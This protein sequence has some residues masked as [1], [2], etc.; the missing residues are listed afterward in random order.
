MFKIGDITFK[1]NIFLAPMAGVTDY[2]FREICR[3]FG[4]GATYTEMISAKG[5][6]YCNKNTNLLMDLGNGKYE[7]GVQLFGSD[8]DI[9]RYAA[10]C[11]VSAG[12]VLIDINM[13][14]PAPKIVKNGEGCALMAKPALVE[15][16]ISSVTEAVNIPVTV[17]IRKG[18]GNNVNAAEIAQIAQG[19]GAAAITVHG[20]TQSEYY[21]GKADL[22]IIARVKQSVT[23]P[24]IGNGDVISL[25]SAKEMTEKTG[26][27]AVMIGRAAMGNPWVFSGVTP[28]QNERIDIALLHAKNLVIHKG[29]YIGVREARKHM[30]WY[31][32]GMKNAAK[33]KVMINKAESLNE[34]EAILRRL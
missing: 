25:A 23:I 19:A 20:R 8:P 30:G 17:K 31:I 14:C 11:A 27:D 9:L 16:I 33:Y 15:K 24:V 1:N 3:N 12:A 4:A 5:I 32:T 18:A 26:C 28:A 7:T 22:N 29:E 13:G 6:F 21:S 34:L 10:V 2:T